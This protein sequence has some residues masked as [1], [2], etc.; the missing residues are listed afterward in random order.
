MSESDSQWPLRLVIPGLPR[1]KERPRF[2]KGRVYTPA[3]TKVYESAIA[4][5][6]KVAMGRRE[7][8][9]GPVQLTVRCSF[10]GKHG[11]HTSKP[12]ASNILKCVEDGMIGIIYKD[13]AQVSVISLCKI[14][15]LNDEV[16]ICVEPL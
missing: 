11:W 15:G 14:N 16:D 8:L 1:G 4:W 13:D 12:D 6:A 2:G 10:T 3:K 5:A 7:I 9:T